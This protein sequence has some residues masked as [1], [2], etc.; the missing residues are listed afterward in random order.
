[1][2]MT[3]AHQN[4]QREG[5]CTDCDGHGTDDSAIE[6]NG[7]CFSCYGT[8]HLHEGP[9]VDIA[10]RVVQ[11][12]SAQSM[13]SARTQQS[14]SG[15]L[16]PSDLGG[17]RAYIAHTL[18]QTPREERSTPPWAAFIGTA[19]GELLERAYVA[20]WPGARSQVRIKVELPSGRRTE[21]SCDVLD[22][23]G[24]ID[25][26]SLNGISVHGGN[27]PF[28][29]LAQIMCYLL[30]A[31]QMGL[32]PEDA[33]W[34][35]VYVD[36]SGS[37]PVPHVVSGHLDM[38]VIHE[39]EERVAEAEYAAVFGTE[40]P[41]DQ[42]YNLCEQFCEFVRTCRGDWQPE[43][44]IDHPA[45]LAAVDRYLEGKELEKRGKAL[46]E[47]AKKDLQG[48]QG[49]TGYATVR[50]VVVNGGWVEGFQRKASERID[51]RKVK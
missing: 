12:Y 39:M 35:L 20:R 30:G 44:L 50:K 2:E 6:S 28:K 9:C 1:M 11:A 43:G 15:I 40:A 34:H 21:G 25:F 45:H 33:K 10:D 36:R 5:C 49:S 16:G 37:E 41:R 46:R 8:G 23:T 19:V 42:P 24:V 47:S 7:R 4:A 27:V 32:L 31:I 48:V 3:G 18:M 26:K 51:V 14:R 17:C 38:D 22:E 13:N 29:N